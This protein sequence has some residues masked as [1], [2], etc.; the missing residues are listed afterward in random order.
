V[1]HAELSQ[2]RL[3]ELI[4]KF[5]HARIG[6][7]GDF[8]LD[9]YLDVDPTL[10]ERSVETGRAAHQVTGIR[11]SPGCAGTVICN[12]AS[13][14]VE[15]LYAIGFRGDDGEGYDLCRRLC[16]LKCD[17]RH[18]H[19]VSDRYTPTYLKPRNRNDLS[20]AGEY[21]RYDTKNRTQTSAVSE[22]LIL[23]SLDEILPHVD[24]LMVM[25]Q[26]EEWN[27]GVV[28]DRVRQA[29]IERAPKHPNIVFWADSRRRIR[30]YRHVIIKPNQ[31]E[32]VGNKTISA[33][34]AIELSVLQA[35][36]QRLRDE[37]AAPIVVTRGPLGMIVSD[38]TW[39]IVPG[40]RLQGE[41]DTTGAGDSAS[42][43][44]VAALCA[45]AELPEAVVVANLIASIT[46]EQLATTGVARTDQLSARLDL[47]H[48]QQSS[49][50]P[51]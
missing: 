5:P 10:E 50:E 35:A 42:A 29:I 4:E 46:I 13:L 3:T 6:V 36:A 40:V 15:T 37:V 47:W 34:E 48:H 7:L 14:G 39:T 21:N 30:E 31:F 24:A 2:Q 22:T 28:T 27:C 49:Q 26:V 17:T 19:C 32:T 33:D 18:L 9:K 38:P 45:G 41:L 8:F 16:E 51:T 11:T 1:K 23:E 12:L 44:S 43:G 20:L 25:D